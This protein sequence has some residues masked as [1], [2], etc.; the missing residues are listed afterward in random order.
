MDFTYDDEQQALR[1]AVRGLLGAAYADHET[2]R[3]TVADEPGFDSADEVRRA[4]VAP[5]LA[6]AATIHE[7]ITLDAPTATRPSQ[8]PGWLTDRLPPR[9]KQAVG[10]DRAAAV[11]R[12]GEEG[13]R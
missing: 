1:E 3:R 5:L 11:A 10:D 8:A 12:T 13:G 9:R 7:R 2:R 4:Y 6:R